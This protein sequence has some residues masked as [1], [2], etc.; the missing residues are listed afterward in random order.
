[1]KL[2]EQRTALSERLAVC[3]GGLEALRGYLLSDKFFPRQNEWI[4]GDAVPAPQNMVNVADVLLRIQETLSEA[5]G[6]DID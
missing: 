5:R 4:W 6:I 3:E 1:M 2:H